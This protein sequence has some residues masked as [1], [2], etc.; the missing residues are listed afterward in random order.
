MKTRRVGT[1]TAGVT[2][3]FAP[4]VGVAYERAWG[5]TAEYRRQAGAAAGDTRWV[6]GVRWWF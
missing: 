1:L 6:A 5:G 3:Q 2:R 4:Y